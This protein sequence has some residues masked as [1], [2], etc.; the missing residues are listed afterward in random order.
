MPEWFIQRLGLTQHRS[1]SSL[2]GPQNSMLCYFFP[3]LRQF[4]VKPQS[5]VHVLV[6]PFEDDR[7]ALLAIAEASFTS[8]DNIAYIPGD[9]SITSDGGITMAHASAGYKIP[10]F[11]VAKGTHLATNDRSLVVVETK[12]DDSGNYDMEVIQL[13]HY[14]EEIDQRDKQ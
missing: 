4:I 2:Y 1:E 6:N 8:D 7:N 10:D 11:I 5:K 3:L 9:L 13:E 14:M 12:L